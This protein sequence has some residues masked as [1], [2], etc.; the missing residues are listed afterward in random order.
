MNIRNTLLAIA[1]LPIATTAAATENADVVARVQLAD[2]SET[3]A[4]AVLERGETARLKISGDYSIDLT[5]RQGE[6]GEVI[7]EYRFP[8]L[9]WKGIQHLA[10]GH[11]PYGRDIRNAGWLRCVRKWR[12]VRISPGRHHAC[13]PWIGV[14][15]EI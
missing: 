14:G 6:D 2:G 4:H 8:P 15:D 10:H 13:M 9:E 1:A 12:D 3:T 5:H 11:T 7:Y